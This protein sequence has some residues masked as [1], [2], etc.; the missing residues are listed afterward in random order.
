MSYIS[1]IRCNSIPTI[2]Y[3]AC[4]SP[5]PHSHDDYPVQGP[6]DEVDYLVA[7]SW[8]FG[9]SE[10]TRFLTKPMTSLHVNA[11]DIFGLLAILVIRQFY[12]FLR[13]PLR[14]MVYATLFEL[15]IA[16]LNC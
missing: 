3:L 16:T 4:L 6:G 9:L 14:A 13:C 8:N 11:V 12:G 7:L 10:L 2:G 15:A 5:K 1:F